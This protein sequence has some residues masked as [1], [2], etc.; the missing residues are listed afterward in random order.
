M[1]SSF[2]ISDSTNSEVH[3]AGSSKKTGKPR[4]IK[5]YEY[6]TCDISFFIYFMESSF[7]MSDLSNLDFLAKLPEASGEALA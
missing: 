4:K 5:V 7:L 2:F 1:G 6:P 3:Q